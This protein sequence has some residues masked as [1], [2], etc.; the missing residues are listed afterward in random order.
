MR[1]DLIDYQREAAVEVLKRLGRGR[2]DWIE[3]RSLCA[4]AGSL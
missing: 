3:D 1:Y 2:R 4:L